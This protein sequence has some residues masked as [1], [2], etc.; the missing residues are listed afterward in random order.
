M[1]HEVAKEAVDV[2]QR[3]RRVLLV[4]GPVAGGIG[5]HVSSL[6]RGLPAH[7]WDV[8]VLT[9]PASASRFD[10]GPDVHPIWPD[11]LA[12]SPGRV[13][14]LRS[15]ARDDVVAADV[16]HAHGHQAG[17]VALGLTGLTGVARRPVVVSWHNASLGSGVD[18]RVRDL[19]EQWL[20]R[21][22][23]LVTGA[24]SDLVDRAT[25]LGARSAELAPVAA[26]QAGAWSG[27]RD[28][29]RREVAAELGLDPDLPWVLTV[30]RIASQKNLHVI[31][32]AAARLAETL[33]HQW[34]VVGDG[35]EALA[36]RLWGRISDT[37]APVH[38]L[39]ARADVPRLMAVS[40]VFALASAWE[41]RALVVQEAFAAGL[42]VVASRAGGLTDLVHG[43][44]VLVPPG[45][46]DALAHS[47]GSLLADPE[48]RRAVAEA[49]RDRFALLPDEDD[50]LTM[51]ARTYQNL[52]P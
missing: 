43:V 41:A 47:V 52:A 8:T 5:V 26:P 3:R 12:S 2:N 24:S 7:G 11:H 39:G 19:T 16:V 30:S 33:P 10:F 1:G 27:D 18:R 36:A 17:V 9:T 42:A 22:A 40:D 32:D 51:W 44:G 49:G 21:R 4:V 37:G 31:V 45:D 14:H 50:V 46:A 13:L 38:L 28:A 20:A 48:R 6:A 29:E 25:R 23:D 34:L 15:A 35:D